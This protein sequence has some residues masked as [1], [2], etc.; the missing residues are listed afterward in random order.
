MFI[1]SENLAEMPDVFESRRT[2]GVV[3]SLVSSEGWSYSER[4]PFAM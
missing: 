3:G 4:T 2:G 1:S